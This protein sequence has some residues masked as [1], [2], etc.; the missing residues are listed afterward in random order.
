MGARPTTMAVE[1]LSRKKLEGLLVMS[2]PISSMARPRTVRT[3]PLRLD[4]LLS[5]L[6]AVEMPQM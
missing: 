6:R 4:L 5:Q 3:L 2:S 1:T